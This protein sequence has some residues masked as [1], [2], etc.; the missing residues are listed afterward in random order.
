MIEEVDDESK[1]SSSNRSEIRRKE[2]QRKFRKQMS[3]NFRRKSKKEP[4]EMK[5]SSAQQLAQMKDVSN[6][7]YPEDSKL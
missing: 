1:Q 5:G 6:L 7:F 3:N 4:I 2:A